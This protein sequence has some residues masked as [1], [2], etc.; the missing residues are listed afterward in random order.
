MTV[1]NMLTHHAAYP[2]YAFNGGGMYQP[3]HHSSTNNMMQGARSTFAIHELLG[4]GQPVSQEQN[5]DYHHANINSL[6]HY[7]NA[8]QQGGQLPHLVS[9]TNTGK[10]TLC[11]K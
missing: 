6:H 8:Q 1:E 10:K 5:T 4:L 3:P 11:G 2:S 9:S 7:H